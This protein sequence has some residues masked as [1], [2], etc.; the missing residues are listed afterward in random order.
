MRSYLNLAV[1]ALAASTISPALTAPTRYR[2]ES[3]LVKFKGQAFL[4]S[5]IPTLGRIPI[6]LTTVFMLGLVS[7]RVSNPP[8]TIPLLPLLLLLPLLP[9]LPLLLLIPL[10]PLLPLILLVPA[11]L[12][13]LPTIPFQTQYSHLLTVTI[14]IRTTPLGPPLP[15]FFSLLPASLPLPK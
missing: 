4:I 11:S 7:G 2:Y 1:L 3:S 13:P 9:L 10:L 6:L 15:S 8:L 5:G 14:P 12:I